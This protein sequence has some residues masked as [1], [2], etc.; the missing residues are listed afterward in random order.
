MSDLNINASAKTVENEKTRQQK[1]DLENAKKAKESAAKKAEDERRKAASKTSASGTSSGKAASSKTSSASS[2]K[3]SASASSKA[4]SENS[5][6]A[7][8]A[9]AIVGAIVGAAA[10]GIQNSG[11]SS[12]KKSSSKGSFWLGGL[13]GLIVGAAAVLLIGVLSNGMIFG[14]NKTSRTSADEVLESGLIGYTAVDF[15]D[16]VLGEASRHQELIVMEQPLEITTTVTKAGLQNLRIFSKTKT[17]TYFGTGVY[18]VDM[19][20]LD[21]DH[22]RVDETKKQVTI[23]IPRTCLQYIN[24]D[25]DKTEFEDTERGLLSFGDLKLTTEDQNRLLQAVYASMEERLV[26]ADLFGM[27]DEFAQMSAWQMFQP[28][29]TA[30][31]P[32][33]TVEIEFDSSTANEVTFKAED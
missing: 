14:T 15:Q 7:A 13:I 18:T 28:L 6:S 30:I 32:E 21:K 11:K 31:S 24:P 17:I 27:A 20:V 2:S 1:E 29:V 23:I 16:A 25:L 19:A 8:G 9:G 22:V 26:S 12:N 33:Y 5:A 3:A 10:E 4:S